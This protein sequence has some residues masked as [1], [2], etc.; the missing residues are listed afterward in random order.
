MN[1]LRLSYSLLT[2]WDRGDIQRAVDLY[3]HVDGFVNEA[4]INGRK[5]HEEIENHII[6][7]GEFP[8]WFFTYELVDP[9]PEEIVIV[10]YNELFNIKGIF[11]CRDG[12]T[13]FEFK[14]GGTDSLAWARTW[15]LPI[16]FLIAEIAEIEIDKAFLIRNNGEKTDFCIVHNTKKKREMAANI[17]DS[18]APE[19]YAYFEQQGLV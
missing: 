5:V 4:M 12:T 19:I 2:T 13:L 17:I 18:I 11:D 9:K 8:E 3:F 16:Y 10:E 1:K 15:Q 6:K 7:F 14:T